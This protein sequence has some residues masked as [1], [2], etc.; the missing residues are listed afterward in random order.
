MGAYLSDRFFVALAKRAGAPSKEELSHCRTLQLQCNEEGCAVSLF[1]VARA[2]DLIDG[3][4][5]LRLADSAIAQRP[6]YA[7]GLLHDLDAPALLSQRRQPVEDEHVASD[8][9]LLQSLGLELLPDE[10]NNERLPLPRRRSAGDDPMETVDLTA[11]QRLSFDLADESNR[12]EPAPSRSAADDGVED[13]QLA[14]V[15]LE[16][17]LEEME[18]FER[19]ERRPRW[20]GRRARR[21]KLLRLAS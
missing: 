14:S 2:T 13:E 7:S 3:E 18:R 9:D 11:S 19:D 10:L 15:Q 1:S 21:K 6:G 12:L 20:N 16:A 4:R 5:F 17:L 8:A